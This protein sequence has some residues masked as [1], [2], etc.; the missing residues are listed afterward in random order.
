[1]PGVGFAEPLRAHP[2]ALLSGHPWPPKFREPHPRHALRFGLS[3]VSPVLAATRLFAS[4]FQYGY[5]RQG[6]A[7]HEFEECAAAGG[8]VGDLVSYAVFVN[9]SHGVAAAGEGEGVAFGDG[10]CQCF[11]AVAELVEFEY[12]NRAVPQD[13][14]GVFEQARELAGGFRAYVEDHVVG[15]DV[16]DVFHGGGGG[17]GEFAGDHYINR[18]RDFYAAGAV[19]GGVDQVVFAQGF[20]D[21]VTGCGQEGV[22]DAAADDD[23]VTHFFQGVEYIQFGGDFG[24]ANDGNHR[25]GRVV[26]GLAEGVEFCCQQRARAG[27][28]GEFGYAVGRCLSAVGGA[29]GVH[30][31]D[32]AQGRVLLGQVFVVFLFAFVKADVFEQHYFTVSHFNTTEIILDQAHILAQQGAQ[33]FGDRFHGGGFVVHA[34]F[35]AA[36]VGHQHD[37]GAG[38]FGSLDGRQRGADAGVAGHLAVFDR[39]VQ[40]FTN[41][42][43]LAGEVQVSHF[44]DGHNLNSIFL[45]V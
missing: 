10:F 23:L 43:P 8:D 24:A 25:F 42:N 37:F 4:F 40:V 28:G 7:F 33:V 32:V 38:V 36:Q 14:F 15:A 35:R 26:E 21:R 31:V 44:F 5:C 39:H 13:G 9:G 34:F 29:E 2:C 45:R 19:F 30:H 11:G 22:G 1:M 16:G 27:F 6:F 3:S 41:Q 18:Q 20:A 17:F 12:A